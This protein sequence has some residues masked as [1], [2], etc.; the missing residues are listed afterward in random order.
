MADRNA[1]HVQSIEPHGEWPIG[2]QGFRD[3]GFRDVADLTQTPDSSHLALSAAVRSAKSEHSQEHS[4][5]EGLAS[6]QDRGQALR[7]VGPIQH[8]DHASA[9]C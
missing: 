3:S 9:R 1:G 4:K 7:T 5:I 2:K 6:S 8:V